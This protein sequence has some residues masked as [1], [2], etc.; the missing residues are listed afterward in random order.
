MSLI[1]LL[2]FLVIIGV[3][4]WAVRA[5]AGAFGIP[6]PIVVVVQVILVIV[7]LVW[8]LQNLGLTGG[9]I[10]RLN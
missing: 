4:F 7:A 2:V 6:P 5:L 1:A 3:A 8:L 10:L 9:P